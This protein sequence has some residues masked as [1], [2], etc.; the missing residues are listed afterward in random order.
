M[1]A[2]LR[3]VGGW[4]LQA[5]VLLKRQRARL[6]AEFLRQC[7][8]ARRDGVSL[9]RPPACLATTVAAAAAAAMEAPDEASPE[10]V[11][12][13]FLRGG[14]RETKVSC[15][16][17]AR[18]PARP[19]TYRLTLLDH[20]RAHWRKTGSVFPHPFCARAPALEH[21]FRALRLGHLG[22]NPHHQRNIPSPPHAYHTHL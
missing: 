11:E 7:R 1:R 9:P 12:A 2:A 8:A 13:F 21:N 19:S 14:Q 16:Q 18:L 6:V 10:A 3:G 5:A 20:G 4:S 22:L 17:P 15:P